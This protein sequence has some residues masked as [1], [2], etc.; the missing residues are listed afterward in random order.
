[1]ADREEILRRLTLGDVAYL[2]ALVSERGE[3][4][5]AGL[6]HVGQAL[7]KLGALTVT[8]GSDVT[9]QQTVGAAL[10]AGLTADEVVDTLVVLAPVIG[11]TRIM[12]AA[13]KVAQAT[14][15]DVVAALEAP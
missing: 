11:R 8:D 14:G 12:A 10:D 3:P 6:D 9:W 2:D 15:F 1:M 5:C 13:P 4:G 7:V